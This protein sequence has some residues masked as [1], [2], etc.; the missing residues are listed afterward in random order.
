MT[1][2]CRT[3]GYSAEDIQTLSRWYELFY[4]DA[5]YR[6]QVVASWEKVMAQVA[7]NDYSSMGPI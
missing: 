2:S 6:R 1:N 4:P 5:A 7:E 3:F